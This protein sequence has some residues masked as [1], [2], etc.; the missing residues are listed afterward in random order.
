MA[1]ITAT[2]NIIDGIIAGLTIGTYSEGYKTDDSYTWEIH[3]L[4]MPNTRLI[5]TLHHQNKIV[6]KGDIRIGIYQAHLD[7]EAETPQT[8]W[9]Y[10]IIDKADY[11][12]GAKDLAK[13]IS[14]GIRYAEYRETVT[15]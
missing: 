1:N 6:N 15:A 12:I 14:L 7:H 11:Y 9:Q 8:V 4:D 2:K 10:E 13:K 5:V 3:L